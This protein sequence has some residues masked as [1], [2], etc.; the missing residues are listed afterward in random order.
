M[1]PARQPVGGTPGVRQP[2][3]RLQIETPLEK[4][5][6]GSAG[7]GGARCGLRDERFELPAGPDLGTLLESRAVAHVPDQ[8]WGGMEGE[9][10][11]GQIGTTRA[12]ALG[13]LLQGHRGQ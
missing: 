12:S 7:R 1:L 3:D 4:A 5:R 13:Y 8:E 2:R 11:L 6:R 10:D 9:P